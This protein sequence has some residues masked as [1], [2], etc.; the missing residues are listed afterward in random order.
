MLYNI[1]IISIIFLNFGLAQ[2]QREKLCPRGCRCGLPLTV[3]CI[4]IGL[5]RIP[6]V[7]I[8]NDTIVLDLRYNQ[9]SEIKKEDFNTLPHLERLFLGNN[10]LKDIE[11]FAF[12]N[13]KKLKHLYLFSNKLE[14]INENTFSGLSKLEQLYLQ[15]NEIERNSPKAYSDLVSLQRLYL[16]RNKLTEIDK[17]VL[18]PM[19]QLRRLKLSSNH[20]PCTCQFARLVKDITLE[21]NIHLGAT[22]LYKDVEHQASS[23]K[24]SD[25]GCY[26]PTF[27]TD[28][29]RQIAVLG[30]IVKLPCKAE[31]NPPPEISWL[32]DGNRINANVS[33]ELQSDGTLVL[34]PITV[35]SS[36]FYQCVAENVIGIKVLGTTVGIV[37]DEVI[38]TFLETP[39]NIDAIVDSI[40][41]FNCRATGY[42]RPSVIWVKNG[43]L[44]QEEKDRFK[45]LPTGDLEIQSLQ[46][47][48]AGY[49]TCRAENNVGSVTHTAK[50]VVKAPPSFTRTPSNQNILDG[51]TA[52]FKCKAT[53]YP[54]PAIA[55][56]KDGNRLPS[57]G[58][59]VVLPSGTLRIL[60]ARKENA[61]TYE[62]QA[63]NVIGVVAVRANLSV[64]ARIK[65]KITVK[66]ADM[67]VQS[68]NTIT[69]SCAAEGAPKP[70][71]A[72]RRNGVQVTNGNRF[73]VNSVTGV[74]EIKD[75]GNVDAGRWE[76]VSRNS[77][78]FASD[79]FSL[80]VIGPKNG[81]Y[82]GDRFVVESVKQALLEVDG[83][84]EL[85]KKKLQ[86]FQ[87]RSPADLL[88]LFRFPSPDAIKIARSAEIFEIA[89]ELIQKSVDSGILHK[90]MKQN[91]HFN[92][93]VSPERIRLLANLS[94]C[95]AHHRLVNCSNLCFHRKY[96][97]YD[98]SCNN[99]NHPMWGAA[100]T[101][102]SRLLIPNY[103]NGFNTPIGWNDTQLPSARKVSLDIISSANVTAD[104]QYTHMLMQWGQ[105]LDHDM[106]FTVASP[107][108]SRFNDGTSCR[109]SCENQQPC[110]PIKIPEDDPR[111]KRFKCMEFTRSSAVCGSGS[112]SVFFDTITPRQQINQITS[113]IDASNVYG[114]SEKDA[115]DLRSFEEDSGYLKQGMHYKDGKFLLP[116]NQN[117]PI[118][119]Q[120]NKSE[121]RVPCFLTGDHRGN[122]Q[123]GLLS[124]HTLWMRQHNLLARRLRRFNPHWKGEKIYQEARKIVGAQ[125]QHISYTEWLPKILGKQGMAKLGEYTGYNPN[126]EPT[127]FNAFATA[128]FRFGHTLIQPFLARLNK[129]F[130]EIPEGNLPLHKAFFSPYRLIEEGGIDPLLRGLFGTP[131]KD[132]KA[133]HQP[134]NSELTEHLFEM[135]HAVALDL[136]ALN[137]QR[138][139]D[140]GLPT[141]K[142]W[143]SICNM[144]DVNRFEDLKNEIKN[145]KLREKLKTI[146]GSV[147]KI[148]LIV[149]GILED[150]L[151]GSNL[152]PLF[153]C[154]ISLQFKRLRDGDRFWYE[155]P[156]VFTPEQLTQIKQTTLSRVICDN[157]DDIRHVQ[158][159]VFTR[160]TR[161]SD[162]TPC[163]QHPLVDVRFWK[164]CCN[165][166]EAC[167]SSDHTNTLSN[168]LQENRSSSPQKRSTHRHRRSFTDIDES[169]FNFNNTVVEET[170]LP[171]M[172]GKKK[173]S[174]N[175][176]KLRTKIKS[177]TRKIKK[178]SRILK[179]MKEQLSELRKEILD[180]STDSS[181]ASSSK[182][183]VENDIVRD[184]GEHWF[185]I[186]NRKCFCV[187][188]KINC[189]N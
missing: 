59:H 55:W 40:A 88:A 86:T 15:N 171:V 152:G 108:T 147:D 18:L 165:G 74:I 106:D 111:I 44:I 46:I 148:D 34:S 36:G 156:G 4:N 123:L 53:G 101:P 131:V 75:I 103:E 161:T 132:R 29:T 32:K 1:F 27:I 84:I 128:A 136:A 139:R 49:Y 60:Y 154:L 24:Y 50:L 180:D 89:L 119:C 37:A 48:D 183:C 102:F 188:K 79:S 76:C 33:H 63:I 138:G 61:G 114:S 82:E 73:S 141:Y 155:N 96:R 118:D 140:H 62:C 30:G 77:V 149:G 176:T 151:P 166:D 159:D 7:N 42:P 3:R 80:T 145:K 189:S 93:L 95:T 174:K 160:V 26:K 99:F 91:Y 133:T 10:L 130:D 122:E 184:D 87:P 16:H 129:S 168:Y 146:Y 41:L 162:Y 39:T 173:N 115:Y 38:P 175:K 158:R 121:S 116:F 11:P 90:G 35:E 51:E 81:T 181:E 56:L 2:R 17:R 70:V 69:F 66:P 20:I 92:G 179:E 142:S 164:E 28:L 23:L 150:P 8:P 65:P 72:W 178:F 47:N 105:F 22:C 137:I 5:K 110:F 120:V 185:D 107:S 14:S 78:G 104:E 126:V 19:K 12:L 177:M 57:D 6:S 109:E 83:A 125:M 21:G 85:T 172:V 134:F 117:T 71:I 97:S 127:I 52:S 98:G 157:S 100:L 186:F 182:S 13:L 58:K 54:A 153:M 143:R 94:G 170:E 135:A 25:L 43:Q 113:F 169:P 167:S 124:M 187:N 9:I 144:S 67:T 31:G 45:L 163:S 64:R 112:T 68:G